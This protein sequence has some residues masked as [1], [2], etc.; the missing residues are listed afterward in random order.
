LTE[1]EFLLN[2][3]AN[4]FG[5]FFATNYYNSPPNATCIKNKHKSKSLPTLDLLPDTGETINRKT[6]GEVV[7]FLI[8]SFDIDD[9]DS[10]ILNCLPEEM[11]TNVIMASTA[12]DVLIGSQ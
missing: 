8:G 4:S 3:L 6:L 1:K 2:G 5:R 10:T 9:F 11:P 7:C 12:S